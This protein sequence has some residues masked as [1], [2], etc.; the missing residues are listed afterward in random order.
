MGLSILVMDRQ[1]RP[2]CSLEQG[3]V[4]DPYAFGD[5]WFIALPNPV[6]VWLPISLGSGRFDL[7]FETFVRLR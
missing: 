6:D 4:G 3:P 2:K 5:G 1:L 7:P